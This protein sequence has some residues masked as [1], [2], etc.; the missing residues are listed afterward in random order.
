MKYCFLFLVLALVI[1]QYPCSADVV[2]DT[3][4]L[5]FP[6]I[7][8]VLTISMLYLLI[9]FKQ[10]IA[11]AELSLIYLI[12]AFF[13]L[14]LQTISISVNYIYLTLFLL[15]FLISIAGITKQGAN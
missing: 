1:M 14:L 13:F 15:L 3:T 4:E 10:G 11:A 12:F 7:L 8:Y 2:G 9:A 6:L 5:D